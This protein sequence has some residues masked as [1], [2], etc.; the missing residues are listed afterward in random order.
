MFVV[1]NNAAEFQP[2]KMGIA[3]D[4]YFE[5]TGGLKVGSQAEVTVIDPSAH[6]DRAILDA[7]KM[8]PGPIV[9][10]MDILFT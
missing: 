1:R 4:K 3:G 8:F 9:E 5:V 10:L 7:L 2:I 6:L